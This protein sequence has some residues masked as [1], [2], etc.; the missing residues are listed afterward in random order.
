MGITEA[1]KKVDDKA[2]KPAEATPTP[3][4]APK[5][6]EK[7]PEESGRANSRVQDQ[8]NLSPE[9]RDSMEDEK[10]QEDES[11][12]R[13]E[14]LDTYNAVFDNAGGDHLDGT[15]GQGDLEEIAS[16]DYNRDEARQMLLEHGIGE[17][18]V[19]DVLSQVEETSRYYLDNPDELDALDGA[20]D[21]GHTDGKIGRGD[22]DVSLRDARQQR[23]EGVELDD[24]RVT[25]LI[26][27]NFGVYD[28][29]GGGGTDGKIS[30]DD[31]EKVASG[32]YNRDAAR[33]ALRSQGVSEQ[34][35]DARL[36][37][38]E[39]GADHLLQDENGLYRELDTANDK[40]GDQDGDIRRGDLDRYRLDH[41]QQAQPLEPSEQ[42]LNEARQAYQDL[43]APGA[44]EEALTSRPNL[45]DYSPGELL[46]LAQLSQD[47]PA[48]QA[49][50]QDHV[51]DAVDRAGSLDELPQGL[52]FQNLLAGSGLT[53]PAEEGQ[54]DPTR[55][56]LSM[57]VKDQLD[58]SLDGYLHDR[59]G[60]SEADL[61]IDRY[62]AD[63]QDLAGRNP[64]LGQQ[65]S[66]LAQQSLQDH[67]DRITDVRR[68]DD[69]TLSKIG[70]A[71]TD[72]FNDVA[73]FV[74]DR[75]RDLGDL[76]GDALA[77]QT[78]LLGEVGDFALTQGG[79]LAG[80]GLDLVGAEGAA[81]FVR[82]GS[83]AAGDFYNRATDFVADQQDKF[84]EGFAEG[85]AGTVE[86][87]A[88]VATNPIGTAKGLAAVVRD[89]SL[90][91][92][93]YKQIL[94]E[95]GVAG[96]AGA[97]TFEVA[98]TVA[99]GG[100]E[101][102]AKAATEVG[103]A[104]VR[105]VSLL[106]EAGDVGRVAEHLDDAGRLGRAGEELGDLGVAGRS[107]DDL[108]IAGQGL[109]DLGVAGQGLDDLGLAGRGVDEAGGAARP[110]P[111]RQLDPEQQA[112]QMRAQEYL[113][114]NLD[115][116]V[117]E[118][119][120]RF[121]NVI[122]LDN[123][124]ELFDEY[125]ASPEARSRFGSA[126]HQ[127]ASELVD[128][129]YRRRLAEPVAPGSENVAIFTGGGAGAGKSSALGSVPELRG[130]VDQADVAFDSTLANFD[131][132][133]ARIDEALASGREAGI[134][135]VY[136]DPLDA[137]ANGALP[138]AAET[139]RIVPVEAFA[140]TH[141]KSLATLRRLAEHY[142][143]NPD[144]HIAVI[145]NSR[146]LGQAARVGL[147]D[148]PLT[149]QIDNLTEVLYGELEAQFERGDIPQSVYEAYLREKP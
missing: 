1:V 90:L 54:E 109:E 144:V 25:D 23:R 95:K 34:D 43:Q 126:V 57:L 77:L 72:G 97:L 2:R 130:L 83:A 26:E 137:F 50:L 135:Y 96:L 67:A 53:T 143:D 52:G 49:M 51:A 71:V 94:E 35:L 141:E 148:L 106:D 11:T 129:I 138:R 17:D 142:A 102:G 39:A 113:E 46:A 73:G 78:R 55:E 21:G 99:T 117:G 92:D 86:G 114:Q 68:D 64:A 132:S 38:I 29:P 69:S 30:R 45:A 24:S 15:I 10:P 115:N 87:L 105:A 124:R 110:R 36:A 84:V 6:A 125:A 123:A 58:S 42:E 108:G 41:R 63:L 103:E 128:E 37:E 62:V 28:N 133:V 149:N 14:T 127:P 18:E 70:H 33:Q 118:Y 32:E 119:E 44:V 80:A 56:H 65:I 13:A 81:D 101:A 89:P 48:L 116:L 27:G 131:R 120:S 121:G 146:G 19:D 40:S 93:S 75:L 88:A 122:D 16:G 104:G 136:R 140:A 79:K 47:D 22:L 107:L 112:V 76:A 147:E 59:S 4:P 20:D 85:A 91:L 12:R 31:L 8:V 61:G 98:A 74:G 7:K 66:D 139:G 9:A 145:D 3:Q 100:G 134:V 111:R 5:P 82:D 60:D